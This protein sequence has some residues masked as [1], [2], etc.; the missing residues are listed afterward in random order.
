MLSVGFH[1]N[2]ARKD[3]TMDKSLVAKQS[4]VID[5]PVATVWDALTEPEQ[6]KKYL[7]GT[8]AESTWK[9]GDPITFSGEWEGKTYQD[10]GVILQFEP[11]K[12]LEYTYF[13]SMSGKEDKPENY[14][15][16]KMT[17][18]PE[19]DKTRLSIEQSNNES[20]EAKEHSESNWGQV[21]TTIKEMLEK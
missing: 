8:K 13:S 3:I 10:K 7:F 4:I 5:A 12:V 6:I 2:K 19:G 14:G 1:L 17:V 9:V 15:I 20:E 21:F 18:E 11:E 16:V